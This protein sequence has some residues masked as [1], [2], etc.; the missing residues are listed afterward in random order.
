[1]SRF[2]TALPGNQLSMWP[3]ATVGTTAG[4]IATVAPRDGLGGAAGG[5]TLVADPANGGGVIYVGP[6]TDLSGGAIATSNGYPL[7]AGA[8][9]TIS[10]CGD[11]R[12]IWAVASAAGMILRIFGS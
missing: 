12:K 6:Q 4:A 9:I 11:P 3:P 8:S 7:V 10:S 1:M 5:I 2:G